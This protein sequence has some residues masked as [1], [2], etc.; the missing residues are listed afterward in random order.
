[1]NENSTTHVKEDTVTLDAGEM[2]CD[3]RP[4]PSRRILRA[5]GRRSASWPS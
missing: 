3:S 1:M 4:L 5:R 2:R